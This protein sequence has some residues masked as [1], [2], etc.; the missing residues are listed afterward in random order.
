VTPQPPVDPAIQAAR[1]TRRGAIVAAVAAA[2]ITGSATGIGAYFAGRKE[3]VSA[4]PT[5]TRTE[6]TYVTV[7]S[8]NPSAPGTTEPN[9]A[10]AAGSLLR[11]TPLEERGRFVT[12]PQ[13][14]D[15]RTYTTA[16]TT[17]FG[18]CGE[19]TSFRVYQLD[20]KYKRFQVRVG[21]T[22]G[23]V[24]GKAV[25]FRVYLDDAPLDTATTRLAPGSTRVLD[26]DLSNAYRMKLEAKSEDSDCHDV[27]KSAAVWIEPTLG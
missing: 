22:D 6:T 7:T 26:A 12:D 11:L 18:P 1:I 19:K 20:R 8:P 10:L 17:F 4:A 23:S 27:Y 16:L 2:L 25:E 21:L 24:G 15:T 5:E 13:D 14:V 3:G 9:P